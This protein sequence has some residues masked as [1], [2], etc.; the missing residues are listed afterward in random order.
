MGASNTETQRS[1]SEFV[2]DILAMMVA[3]PVVTRSDIF[4]QIRITYPQIDNYREYLT[5]HELVEVT[6]YP[7][8]KQDWKITKK[9]REY[10][11]ALQRADKILKEL[12]A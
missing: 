4:Y 2:R 9:G 10:L 8:G 12:P 7:S 6:V 3:E 5:K 1:R 11:K